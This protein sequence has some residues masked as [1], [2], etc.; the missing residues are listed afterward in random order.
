MTRLV[1]IGSLALAY[2]LPLP[3]GA[4]PW[5]GILFMLVFAAGWFVGFMEGE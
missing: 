4:P 5:L 3:F 1:F 2:L